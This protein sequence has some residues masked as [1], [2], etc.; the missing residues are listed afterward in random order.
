MIVTSWAAFTAIA[1]VISFFSS[2]VGLFA[3]QMAVGIGLNYAARALA[4]KPKAPGFS[5]TG[6]A[7]SGRR[8][9]ALVHDG[10]WR[11]GRLAR[12]CK[13]LGTGR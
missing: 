1:G 8:R 5:R 7:A 9:S 4:G 2:G 6:Q 10:L 12:L 11:N 13:Y 3:L